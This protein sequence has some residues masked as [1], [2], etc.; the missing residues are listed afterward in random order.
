MPAFSHVLNLLKKER[1]S[2]AVYLDYLQR[3]PTAALP[4][5]PIQSIADKVNE[6]DLAIE[7]LE[8]NRG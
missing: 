4:E 5:V 1:A 8:C 3:N 6:F 2:E 7:I